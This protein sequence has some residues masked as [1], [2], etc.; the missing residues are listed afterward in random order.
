MFD[1]SGFLVLRYSGLFLFLFGL[2]FVVPFLL[3]V[4]L[5]FLSE[6]L[7]VLR[8][9]GRCCFSTCFFFVAEVSCIGS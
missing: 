5:F 4:S 2:C 7:A 6:I 1:L 3:V 8:V 9:L